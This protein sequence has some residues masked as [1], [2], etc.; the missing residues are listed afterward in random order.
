MATI[1]NF[2]FLTHLRSD[3]SNHI[4]HFRAGKQVKSGRGLAFWF[5]PQRAS[6]AELPID[7]REMSLFI[8]GRSQD[9]Q[10]I[11]VQGNVS[12]HI[13]NPDR[14]AER[15][16]FTVGLTTGR[17][18]SDPVDKIESRIIGLAN[19]AV[20]QYFSEVAVRTLLNA[21]LDPI[22]TR[23]EAALLASPALTD[24]GVEIV[25]VRLSHIAPSAELERALQTPTFEGLQ[26]KADEAV[27]ERRALAV[28]KERAIAENE[29]AN[30]TE[31]AKRETQLIAQESENTSAKAVAAAQANQ[32]E[33]DAQAARIRTVEG[34]QAEAE[35]SRMQ[36]YRD[37]PSHVM[38]GLAA[39]EF[40]TKLEGINNLNITPDLLSALVGEFGKAK[41]DGS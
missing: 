9:F 12:W 31:L 17:L 14:M 7:D 38:M 26:Q 41:S 8:K 36:I 37:L 19:Q 21:G 4:I 22:R 27:F 29:L 11:S 39:R 2:G 34:A 32:I 16:D 3:A 5:L 20:V 6:I 40:A 30:K 24:I 23:I 10:D 13:A 35:A 25:A 28:D 18:Q 33:A 15:V 1:R